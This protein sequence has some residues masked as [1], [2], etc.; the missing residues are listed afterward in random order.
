M[1][2]LFKP[3]FSVLILRLL[4]LF[5]LLLTAPART[6]AASLAFDHSEWDQFLKKF[7]SENGEVN[8]RAARAE[9]RELLDRYLEKLK[10]IPA[11][12]LKNWPREER[13]AVFI[14]AYNAGL[15]KL[16]L[17]HYPLKTVMDIPGV[18]D[19]AIISISTPSSPD[20]KEDSDPLARNYSLNEIQNE[21]LRKRFRDEKIFFAL[22]S[23]AQG[24]PRLAR[25]AYVGPL[26][27]GQLY[28]A[29][30]DF[31]NDPAKNQIAPGHKKVMLSRLFKWY[32]NDFLLNW[33]NFP[34]EKGWEPQE[35]AVLSFLAHYLQDPK[36]VEFL[37][38]GKY[39]VKY[40]VFDWQLNDWKAKSLQ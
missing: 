34:E 19:Q 12:E 29:T 9:G 39:K 31:V 23:G 3:S 27:E 11:L 30:R 6:E 17:E 18:W 20:R 36:Q 13:M 25:E 35:M 15:V 26:L 32:A 4:P 16:I 14:N 21:I 1:N 24:S 8:Y 5:L 37:K 33:G 38:E 40:E 7:V 28:R 10:A 22:C 2:R